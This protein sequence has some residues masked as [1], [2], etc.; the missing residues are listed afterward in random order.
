MNV[1]IYSNFNLIKYMDSFIIT[2]FE[3][4]ILRTFIIVIQHEYLNIVKNN[5]NVLYKVPKQHVYE[6][7][8][9]SSVKLIVELI[10][11]NS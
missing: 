4:S 1:Y 8:I 5:S 3:L 6:L 7:I 11:N 9:L 10:L 2:E